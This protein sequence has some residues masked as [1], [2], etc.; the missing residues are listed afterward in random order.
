MWGGDVIAGASPKTAAGNRPAHHGTKSNTLVLPVM[1]SDLAAFTISADGKSSGNGTGQAAV[2]NQDGSVNSAG[3]AAAR[4][5]FISVYPTG[6]GQ[7]TLAGVNGKLTTGTSVKIAL[8]VTA[9]IGGIPATVQYVGGAPGGVAGFM[10]VNLQIPSS[11]PTGGER[12]SDYYLS[13]AMLE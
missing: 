10:Q 4:N 9:T 6:A 1:A 5:S 11:A 12:F 7:T 2:I 3:N 8:P 13:V